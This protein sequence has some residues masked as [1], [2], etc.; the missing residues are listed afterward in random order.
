MCIPRKAR[1]GTSASLSG[2]A[3]VHGDIVYEMLS[4]EAGAFLDSNCRRLSEKDRV[5]AQPKAQAQPQ[6]QPQN[7]SPAPAKPVAGVPAA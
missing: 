5:Q 2:S 7:G 6:P 1:N 3:Y 4:I